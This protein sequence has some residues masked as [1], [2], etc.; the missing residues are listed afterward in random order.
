M[1]IMCLRLVKNTGK[2]DALFFHFL[3]YKAPFLSNIILHLPINFTNYHDKIN[4]SHF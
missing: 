1:L 2:I 4:H 3:T